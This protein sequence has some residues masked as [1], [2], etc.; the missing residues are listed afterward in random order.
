MSKFDEN[1]KFRDS[2]N[3]MSPLRS[4]N[5]TTPKYVIIELLE[6]SDKEKIL[7][8]GT[9]GSHIRYRGAKIGIITD[10]LLETMQAIKQE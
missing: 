5:K 4:M 10:F 6:T 3:S 1:C 8:A 2:R 7:K 9:G